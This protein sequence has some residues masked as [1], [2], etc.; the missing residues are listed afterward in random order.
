MTTDGLARVML[1]EHNLGPS[2]ALFT[3]LVNNTRYILTFP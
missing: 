1:D 2:R 3:S